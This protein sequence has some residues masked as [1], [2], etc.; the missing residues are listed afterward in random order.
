MSMLISIFHFQNY[1]KYLFTSTLID[2]VKPKFDTNTPKAQVRYSKRANQS[3]Q[4]SLS[5][6][7]NPLVNSISNFSFPPITNIASTQGRLSA[8]IMAFSCPIPIN[9]VASASA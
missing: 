3:F 6:L 4:S 2:S 7:G 5:Y 9:A 8:K 1:Y